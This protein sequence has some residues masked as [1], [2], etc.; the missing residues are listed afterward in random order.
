MEAY[1]WDRLAIR[2]NKSDLIPAESRNQRRKKPQMSRM[3]R[4]RFSGKDNTD[5]SIPAREAIQDSATD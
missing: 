3:T 4:I 1:P 2:G 5:F